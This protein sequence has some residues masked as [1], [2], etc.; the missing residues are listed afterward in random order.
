[1]QVCVVFI[2]TDYT[3]TS[4][5]REK[6]KATILASYNNKYFWDMIGEFELTK[7]QMK[8]GTLWSYYFD[9]YSENVGSLR[10]F[11]IEG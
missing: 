1:M 8:I 7:Y 2:Y 6:R 10:S 11:D 3:Q 4:Y 5:Q 9:C